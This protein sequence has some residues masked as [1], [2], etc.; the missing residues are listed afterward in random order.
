MRG[1][2]PRPAAW[3]TVSTLNLCPTKQPEASGALP[4]GEKWLFFLTQHSRAWHLG[5]LIVATCSHDATLQ[6]GVE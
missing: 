4:C 6:E 1:L 5:G 3:L 2:V